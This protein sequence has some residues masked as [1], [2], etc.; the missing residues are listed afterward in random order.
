MNL[1]IRTPPPDR[2]D[3]FNT[4]ILCTWCAPAVKA[5]Y[6]GANL[7]LRRCGGRLGFTW[8]QADLARGSVSL[9][10]PRQGF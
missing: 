1:M 3:N 5:A 10:L 9:H 4:H 7:H 8:N 6:P 2:G